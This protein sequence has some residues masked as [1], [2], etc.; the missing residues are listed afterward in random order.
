MNQAQKREPQPKQQAQVLPSRYDDILD[1]RLKA[2]REVIQQAQQSTGGKKF[3]WNWRYTALGLLSV[4]LAMSVGTGKDEPSKGSL[5]FD[6]AAVVSADTL[7]LG[8]HS[9][10]FVTLA[11]RPSP[12]PTPTPTPSPTP[13][14]RERLLSR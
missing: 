3:R 10:D 7:G 13:Q 11:P 8:V 5:P 1:Q 2:A 6:R 14:P 4:V 9:S 12:T